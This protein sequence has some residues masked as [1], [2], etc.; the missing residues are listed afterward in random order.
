MSI[1]AKE[2]GERIRY[3][4]KNMGLS[5]EELASRAPLHSMYIGQV[6]HG[7]KNVTV[8]NIGKIAEALDVSLDELFRLIGVQLDVVKIKLY[9]TSQV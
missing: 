4:R 8:E 3:L 9:M 1:F 6:E 5:Q 7:E 2:F